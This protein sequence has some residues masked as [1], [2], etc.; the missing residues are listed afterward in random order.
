[1]GGG[2]GIERLTTIYIYIYKITYTKKVNAIVSLLVH[3]IWGVPIHIQKGGAGQVL[4]IV[5][6]SFL[7]KCI[8]Y[9][10]YTLLVARWYIVCKGKFMLKNLCV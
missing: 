2:W 7:V 4:F 1:M 5:T 8:Y 9:D 6:G 10:N 3:L